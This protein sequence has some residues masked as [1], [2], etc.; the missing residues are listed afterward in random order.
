MYKKSGLKEI[1]IK[2]MPQRNYSIVFLKCTHVQ[3]LKST[4]QKFLCF[5]FQHCD[6]I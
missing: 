3:K 1:H 5:D 2:G 6:A 4:Y